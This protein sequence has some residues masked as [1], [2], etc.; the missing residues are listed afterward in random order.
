MQL[1]DDTL[2]G[3]TEIAQKELL[4]KTIAYM[5]TLANA[6]LVNPNLWQKCPSPLPE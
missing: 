5:S 2:P 1:H 4:E 6:E 3:Y